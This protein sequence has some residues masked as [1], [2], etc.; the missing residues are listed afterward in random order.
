MRGVGWKWLHLEASVLSASLPPD[1][2]VKEKN[3]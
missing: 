1:T 3:Q 2:M